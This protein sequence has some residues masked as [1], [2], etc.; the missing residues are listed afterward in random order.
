MNLFDSA[1]TTIRDM[2]C[3]RT[4]STVSVTTS[5]LLY[6]SRRNILQVVQD[7]FD[8]C[9][10]LTR[11]FCQC[12]VVHIA[13]LAVQ[14]DCIAPD[15]NANIVAINASLLEGI[16]DLFRTLHVFFFLGGF[17]LRQ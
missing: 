5:S 15:F 17:C 3:R 8:A 11:L 12:T 7:T 6:V 13:N 16:H 9:N 4:K 2:V 1:F 10:I 14:L